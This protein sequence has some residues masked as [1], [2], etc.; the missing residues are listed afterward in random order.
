MAR[1]K[2]RPRRHRRSRGPFR[3]DPGR[4]DRLR[5][6][7]QARELIGAFKVRTARDQ[8]LRRLLISLSTFLEPGHGEHL[9]AEGVW[10]VFR[11]FRELA[12]ESIDPPTRRSS[13]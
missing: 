4:L 7:R 12:A 5:W 9:G 10:G 8:G 6:R 11:A 2:R 1:H 13:S 3:D